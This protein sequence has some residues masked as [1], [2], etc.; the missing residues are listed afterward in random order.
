MVVHIYNPSISEG[1]GRRNSKL[2]PAR[3]KLMRSC[4]KNQIKI[5]GLGGVTQVVEHKALGS[6]P[7]ITHT[8]KI[9]NPGAGGTCL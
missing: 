3:A 6:N 2:G 1:R 5:K 4:L 7:S 9:V 8:K